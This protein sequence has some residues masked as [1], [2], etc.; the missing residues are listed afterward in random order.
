MKKRLLGLLMITGTLLML[1][2][3]CEYDFIT[4]AP[5]AVAPPPESDT[6][7]YAQD[8]QPVF[9]AKCDG[10]HAGSLA[11]DLRQGKSYTALVPA[12]VVAGQSE[13]SILYIKCAPG[14]SMNKYCLPAELS[15]IKR[16]I[17]AGAKND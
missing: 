16:W 13:S 12:F 15:L 8:I 4:P 10:C 2:T 1:L 11:P 9:D 17:N 3:A 5:E 14:G 6:I 7:R